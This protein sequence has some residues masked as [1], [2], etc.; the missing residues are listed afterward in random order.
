MDESINPKLITSDFLQTLSV[1]TGRRV[2]YDEF[3]RSNKNALA[4]Y[5]IDCDHYRLPSLKLF[6]QKNAADL[7]RCLRIS[8]LKNHPEQAVHMESIGWIAVPFNQ[9]EK[10]LVKKH[11]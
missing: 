5:R 2:S 4:F 1:L 10:T 6:T 7:N 9:K 3:A 11:F 8:V